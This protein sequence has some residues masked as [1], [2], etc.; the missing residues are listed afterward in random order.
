MK[1]ELS[2]L[3]GRLRDSE[4]CDV[5]DDVDEAANELERLDKENEVLQSQL[6]ESHRREKVAVEHIEKFQVPMYVIQENWNPSECP[7][8]HHNFCDY[9]ECNDGYYTRA[10]SLE[11][12]P[13]CGQ[14]LSWNLAQEGTL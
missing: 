7:R 9:E 14:K 11:R 6:S 4:N 2:E 5:L 13:Y 1:T 3:I 8:C 12:C 10:E